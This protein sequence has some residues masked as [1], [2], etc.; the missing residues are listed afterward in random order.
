MNYVK[1]E[2]KISVLQAFCLAVSALATLIICVNPIIDKGLEL[3]FLLPLSCVVCLVLFWQTIEKT[4]NQIGI[5]ML[6]II[7]GIRY[8]IS[9]LL[10]SISQS[11]VAGLEC[12]SFSYFLAIISAIIELFVLF[13][14]LK[15]LYSN[16][17]TTELFEQY[18]DEIH[19]PRISL[20]GIVVFAAMCG[21]LLIRGH[22]DNVLSH[23]S[24]LSNF[25][26]AKEELYTYDFQ[27]FM[28]LKTIIILLLITFFYKCYRVSSRMTKPIWII[29]TLV[30]AMINIAFY[31]NTAR[32]V[33]VITALSTM[34]ILFRLFPSNKKMFGFILLVAM[35][36]LVGTIFMTDTLY[37][38][39]NEGV[40]VLNGGSSI[41]HL[42]NIVELYCNGITN[43]AYGFERYNQAGNLITIDTYF[44]DFIS[45]IGFLSFPGLRAILFMVKDVP[46]FTDVYRAIAGGKDYIVP[47]IIHSLYWGTAFFALPLNILY[48]YVILRFQR[49]LLIKRAFSTDVYYIYLFVYSELFCGFCMCYDMWIEIHAI[50]GFVIY[51]YIIIVFNKLGRRVRLKT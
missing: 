3:L 47:P 26:Y 41:Q 9:P 19:E 13:I 10:M 36:F 15:K 34:T 30:V 6:Y 27:C 39:N 12:S 20:I 51:T 7:V 46:N 45:Q 35:V 16:L 24:F 22:M 23:I 37:F 14:I 31:D 44:S 28:S 21:L 43:V 32:A 38:F 17:D 29:L 33:L 5:L 40:F 48:Y 4:I 11:T 18:Q 25:K 8:I 42:S 1:N 50:T 49:W 2:N